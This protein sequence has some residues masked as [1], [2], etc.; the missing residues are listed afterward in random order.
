MARFFVLFL[1]L[2]VVAGCAAQPLVSTPCNVG[3]AAPDVIGEVATYQADTECG[4]LSA[5]Y[6]AA[7]TIGAVSQTGSQTRT[8]GVPRGFLVAMIIL[9]LLVGLA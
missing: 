9:I 7:S 2:L 5:Q 3:G 4:S 8:V 6:R 1:A